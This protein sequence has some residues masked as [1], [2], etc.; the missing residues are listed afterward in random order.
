[1]QEFHL[2]PL[3]WQ[4]VSA[5]LEIR[6]V[7]LKEWS[8]CFVAQWHLFWAICVSFLS[9]QGVVLVWWWA[10]NSRQASYWLLVMS[11]SFEYGT[12][13]ER[14]ECRWDLGTKII[15]S[16][17]LW[18]N[19][20]KIVMQ[21]FWAVFHIICVIPIFSNTMPWNIHVAYDGN[22]G[23]TDTVENAQTSLYSDQL[24]FL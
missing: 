7:K 15:P 18:S 10:G 22:V 20:Y 2:C 1:M 6:F 23:C 14:W 16:V 17:M 9:A 8:C 12:H 3:F 11:D 4:T 21:L 5:A 13:S 19:E 24:S